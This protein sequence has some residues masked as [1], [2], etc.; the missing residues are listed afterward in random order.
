[1]KPNPATNNPITND[2][3]DVGEFAALTTLHM[4][5][6]F[7]FAKH[8]EDFLRQALAPDPDPEPNEAGIGP[9]EH[10]ENAAE[11]LE[12][13]G[14]DH[15]AAILRDLAQTAIRG[16]DLL[17]DYYVNDGARGVEN[18]RAKWLLRRKVESGELERKLRREYAKRQRQ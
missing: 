10:L 2:S 4:L 13:R 3:D 5:A 17:P 12:A 7:L 9:R 1:M 16:I 18:W 11:E 6:A 14:L 15:V 8:G